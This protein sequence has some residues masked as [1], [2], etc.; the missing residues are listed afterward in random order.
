MPPFNTGRQSQMI[1]G[2]SPL[3]PFK[4]YYEG[5]DTLYPGYALCSNDD[6]GTAAT[7]DSERLTRAEKP[8]ATNL[9]YFLGTVAPGKPSYVGPCLVPVNGAN[10]GLMDVYT[11]QAC[12]LGTTR[13]TVKAGS[14]LLGGVGQG[15]VVAEAAQTVDRSSTNG[16]CLARVFGVVESTYTHK[17][18]SSALWDNCPLVE[19]SQD[20]HLGSIF[21]DDFIYLNKG[22]YGAIGAAGSA[23]GYPAWA[24]SRN[25]IYKAAVSHLTS[26]AGHP[27][28]A[29]LTAAQ[30]VTT[31]DIG[32][33]MQLQGLSF[34]LAS[35]KHLWFEAEVRMG[36]IDNQMFIGLAE[37]EVAA[38][39][40]G[41]S[42]GV[43]VAEN[44]I[45][46]MD[47][48]AG[49]ASTP[50]FAAEKAT[51]QGKTAAAGGLAT[52]VTATWTTLGFHVWFDATE[53]SRYV[54]VYQDGVLLDTYLETSTE[55]TFSTDVPTEA[56]SP[57]FYCGTEDG[58]TTSVTLDVD[59]IKVVQMR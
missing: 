32:V 40:Y 52:L 56:M 33:T 31:A 59:W 15:I 16:L 5:S 23:T 54:T 51:N 36:N 24:W 7:A 48:G 53:A 4:V 46:F 45:G 21:F 27:G 49:D 42:G 14:Y 44:Y 17:S 38:G 29:R 37:N 19:I 8:S 6:Y 10:G 28:I 57:V 13:L 25:G 30:D 58:T 41:A 22:K 11:D 3:A 50:D 43:N 20:P 39:L 35:T 34:I 12:T 47:D 26:V 9:P 55:V 18:E 1:P 2:P